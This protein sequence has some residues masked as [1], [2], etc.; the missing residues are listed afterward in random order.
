MGTMS[1]ASI[2]FRLG[3]MT[4]RA[5]DWH[6]VTLQIAQQFGMLAVLVSLHWTDCRIH[7]SVRNAR[8]V[9]TR[10]KQFD[11]THNSLI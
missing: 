3:G 4:Y 6:V 8:D 9:Q 10:E 5:G 11:V 7:G 2:A 1:G